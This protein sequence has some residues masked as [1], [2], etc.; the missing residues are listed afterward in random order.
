MKG[1]EAMLNISLLECGRI[2]RRYARLL[3]SAEDLTRQGAL[4]TGA[5]SHVKCD[6]THRCLDISRAEGAFGFRVRIDF[7][8]KAWKDDPVRLIGRAYRR[9]PPVSHPHKTCHL[10]EMER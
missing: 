7:E 4:K 9:V 5:L 3:C 1:F 10:L 2:A 8:G 6:L